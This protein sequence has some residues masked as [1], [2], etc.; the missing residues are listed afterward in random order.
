MSIA[1]EEDGWEVELVGGKGPSQGTLEG[2]LTA[3]GD[4]VYT[5]NSDAKVGDVDTFEYRYKGSTEGWGASAVVSI[6][7]VGSVPTASDRSFTVNEDESKWMEFTEF[8]ATQE[9]F[10]LKRQARQGEVVIDYDYGRVIYYPRA[11]FNGLDSF[12]YAITGSGRESTEAFVQL[13]VTPQNDGPVAANDFLVVTEDA[14][15]EIDV[16]LNDYDVDS[17]PDFLEA[18]SW[19]EIIEGP[20][21]GSASVNGSKIIYTPLPNYFGHDSIVYRLHDRDSGSGDNLTRDARLNIYVSGVPDEPIPSGHTFEM[22]EDQGTELQLELGVIDYDH[23]IIVNGALEYQTPL[24]H[25]V[26]ITSE[27]LLGRLNDGPTIAQSVG[28][29]FSVAYTPREDF[30][31]VTSITYTWYETDWLAATITVPIV[32]LPTDDGPASPPPEPQ[33]PPDPPSILE[34]CYSDPPWETHFV[35]DGVGSTI[36]VGGISFHASGELDKPLI[37]DVDIANRTIA[38]QGSGGNYTLGVNVADVS[39]SGTAES[40]NIRTFGSI[41]P[42]T[43]AGDLTLWSYESLEGMFQGRNVTADPL[44]TSNTWWQKAPIPQI[45]GGSV[46]MLGATSEL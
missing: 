18:G 7:I 24:G 8:G 41:S 26:D 40:L 27:P 10:V 22:Y 42:I 14:S 9:T 2:G 15:G 28:V 4:F 43:I 31:G 17:Q 3:K 30:Y 6:R 11:D 37:V 45:M 44:G 20:A 46:P 29:D 33:P 35:V 32:V 38:L 34:D 1:T 21:L 25:L 12:T 5:P 36:C 23:F 16:L 13:T 19:I 39:F